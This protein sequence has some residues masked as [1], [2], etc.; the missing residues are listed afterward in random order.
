MS[1]ST[2]DRLDRLADLSTDERA[3][4]DADLSAE[5]E[6]A[7]KANDTVE[8]QNALLGLKLLDQFEVAMEKLDAAS[9]STASDEESDEEGEEK[10]EG[11]GDEPTESPE[12]AEPEETPSDDKSDVD[13]VAD[14]ESEAQAMAASAVETEDLKPADEQPKAL[15]ASAFAGADVRGY[16]A[17]EQFRSTEDIAKAMTDQIRAT[18]GMRGDGTRAVVASLRSDVPE[19]RQLGTDAVVNG[20]KIDKVIGEKAIV[21]SGGFCA[22][23]PINYDIFG[24]GST[25]RPVRDSLPTF[26]ATR[27]GIRFIAPPTLGSYTQAISVWT[28]LNDENP[29]SPATKPVLKVNC[30]NELEATTDAITLSL[31][32]G[33]FMTRAFPELVQRHNQL[34]L[35]E[36]ARVAEKTLLSK[37]SALSTK[38]TTPHVLGTARDLLRS[39]SR[40]SAAYRNR[41]RI[42]RGISLRAIMPEWVRDAVREDIATNLRVGTEDIAVSDA[43]VDAW[44]RSRGLTIT[45]HMDDTFAAQGAGELNDFPGT[46]KWWLFTEGTFL[47]LDG[48]TLDLGVVRDA[49]LV[50]TNDYIT[51]VETFEGI[52]K[53]GIEALEITTTTTLGEF[54]APT[55]P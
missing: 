40:A 24:V 34:A 35:I 2:A 12:A 29:T 32:F 31:E 19:D 15:T 28:A 4:L 8:M 42:P 22:P 1:E 51:F 45:W 33:N 52:A 38:V 20:E 13:D 23:L 7:N 55:A 53:V 21:A 49:D 30:A 43:T 41:H 54:V 39:I 26:G 50:A 25:A 17:G 11:E 47:F 46:I 27:G 36:H 10:D 6:K 16:A 48:G 9:T 5:F 18:A 37:I 44:F 14:T 3:Q